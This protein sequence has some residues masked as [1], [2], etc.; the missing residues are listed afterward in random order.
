MKRNTFRKQTKQTK[1]L[2]IPKKNEWDLIQKIIQ[3][4]EEKER[5]ILHVLHEEER[6]SDYVI[7]GIVRFKSQNYWVQKIEFENMLQVLKEKFDKT[8]VYNRRIRQI[9]VRNEPEYH[10]VPEFHDELPF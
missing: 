5:A 2:E 9:Y 8:I 3:Y 6:K 7:W 1:K 10:Q 4:L